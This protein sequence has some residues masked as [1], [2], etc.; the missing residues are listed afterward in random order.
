MLQRFKIPLTRLKKETL[1]LSFI[2]G[3]IIFLKFLF[4][5]LLGRTFGISWQLDALFVNVAIFGFFG[6]SGDYL[7]SLFI[8]VFHEVYNS[9]EKE[10]HKFFDAVLKWSLLFSLVIAF[11]IKVLD[12]RIIKIVASGLSERSILLA[13]EMLDIFVFAVVFSN[14][15]RIISLT[16]N[17]LNY[18]SFPALTRLIYPLVNIFFLFFFVPIYGI[19]SLA[20][21]AVGGAFI[22]AVVLMVFFYHR[23]RW[24]PTLCF[25]HKK[26]PFLIKNSLQMSLSNIVWGFRDIVIKNFASRIGEG[27]ISLFY[28][29]ERIIRALIYTVNF[30]V[31]RVYYSR[32]SQFISTLRWDKVEDLFKRLIRVNMAVSF[33][34]SSAVL[35]FLPSVLRILFLGSK[36]SANDI[37]TITMLVNILLVYFIIVSFENYL[38]RIVI[39]A[40]KMIVVALNAFLGVLV[41]FVCLLAFYKRYGIYSLTIGLIASD[42]SVCVIYALF[43]KRFIHINFLK[44][45]FRFIKSF[46]LALCFVL[47]GIVVKKFV[48]SDAVVIFLLLPFWLVFYLLTAYKFLNEEKDIILSR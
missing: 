29:A 8:P 1:V 35:L 37:N 2:T 13:K 14:V 42:M 47:I 24:R 4:Q 26:I 28:Y 5:V 27:A 39:V 11:S 44:L 22:S 9:G 10:A 12:L 7:I 45:S 15:Q 33:M 16:L 25:Y 41:L 21:A 18:Y 36:F 6:A 3:L 19:K 17:A 46:F 43:V 31:V 38:S 48:Y 23:T 20:F 40:R 34:I 30:S 32:I